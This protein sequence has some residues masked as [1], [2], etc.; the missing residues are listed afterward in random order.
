MRRKRVLQDVG[1]LLFWREPG[2]GSHGPEPVQPR[3]PTYRRSSWS[4]FSGSCSTVLTR[5]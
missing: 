3:A 2:C 1:V 5:A 4:W